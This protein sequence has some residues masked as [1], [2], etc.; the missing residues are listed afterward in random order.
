MEVYFKLSEKAKKMDH[1]LTLN[2]IS[3]DFGYLIDK[4]LIDELGLKLQIVDK[5]P[6]GSKPMYIHGYVITSALYKYIQENSNLDFI[7]ILETGTARGFSSVIMSMILKQNNKKG[8][9]HTFDLVSHDKP[10]F[11]NCLKAKQLKKKLSRKQILEEWNDL[12]NEYIVFHTGDSKK[13]MNK[14]NLDRIHFAFLDGHHDYSYVMFELEYVS[15]RQISGDIITC[16]D[17]TSSQFPTIVKAIDD[18]VKRGTYTFKVYYG[19]D[20]TKKR[21]YV[22]LVKK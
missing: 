3:N 16:D 12:V 5:G 21:G 11:D 10:E 7:N 20:G 22:C 8:I 1:S 4:N 18:F 6:N 19:N 9:V 15:S 17:Y 14:L 2:Q 13:E